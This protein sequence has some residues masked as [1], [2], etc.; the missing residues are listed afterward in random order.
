MAKVKTSSGSKV[1]GKDLFTV[2]QKHDDAV[3]SA[4]EALETAISLRSDAVKEIIRVL[5]KGPFQWQGEVVK[6]VSRESKDDAGTVTKTTHF[7]KSMGSEVQ[8]IG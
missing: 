8:E 2:Y 1:S 4:R 5:G 6:A 7:F 3:T